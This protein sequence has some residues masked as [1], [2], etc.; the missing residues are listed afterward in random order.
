M[1]KNYKMLIISGPSG[2][3]KSSIIDEIKN[4]FSNIYFSISTTTRPQRDGEINGVDYFF[5]DTDDFQDSIKEGKFI[6]F[7]KNYGNFY[8]TNKKYIEDELANNKF[9]IFDIDVRGHNSIKKQYP[10]AFSIFISVRDRKTLESRLTARGELKEI[11]KR[12]LD[13]SLMEL[14]MASNFDFLII[15][16]DLKK[17]TEAVLSI[18]NSMEY[19][20]TYD[21]IENLMKNY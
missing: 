5:V 7:E 14:E 6:E 13:A 1:I 11:I 17:S 19:K 16:D 18:I 9:I 21:K 3:G 2:A 4:N 15:N 10:E 20:N 12:R 8:G